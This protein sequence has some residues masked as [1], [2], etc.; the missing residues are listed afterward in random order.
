M[1]QGRKWFKH[2]RQTK[3]VRTFGASLLELLDEL[4]IFFGFLIA[5]FAG[6][7]YSSWWVFSGIL[8][9]AFLIGFSI[10]RVLGQ[11]RR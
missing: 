4:L 6:F 2:L 9:L 10:R 8:L 11:S 1:S 7:Y 5:L 3:F